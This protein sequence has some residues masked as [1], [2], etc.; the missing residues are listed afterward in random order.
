MEPG[1]I[2]HEIRHGELAQLG[3]LPVPAVLRHPRRDEPV[4][5]R[6]LVPLPVARRRV[7]PPTATCRTPRR[8]CAGSTDTATA[9]ATASRSTRPARRTATTT[10]AGRT[11]ATRSSHADGSLAPL[12]IGAVRAAGLRLRREAPAGRHL[13]DPRPAEGRAAA[14][15]RGAR[16][17]RAGQRAVLVGG[18]GDLLPRPRRRRSGRSA[19]VASNAGH[20][21]RVRHR[22]A[23]AGGAGREAPPRRRHVVRLGHPDAL[24][25]PPRVQ[26]V[27]LPHRHRSG[28]TTAPPT[29]SGPTTTRSSPAASGATASTR[30][31]RGSRAACST[32][33]SASRPPPARA[34]RRP[35]TRRRRASRSSTSGAN[36]PQAWAAGAVFRLIAILAGIHATTDASGSRIYVNPALPDWLPA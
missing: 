26:P 5:H 28:R 27:Q 30:R 2:P 6:P 17:V 31:R 29:P 4:R 9:T 20:L 35:A 11:P 16:A 3:I 24:V 33:P 13:R 14:A 1:K 7:D 22:A 12:P 25:R 23:G 36:V 15:A 18:G 21:P 34:V 19:R 10:R 8:R 32:R